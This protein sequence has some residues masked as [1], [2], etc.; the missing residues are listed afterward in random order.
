MRSLWMGKEEVT[1]DLKDRLLVT[2]GVKKTNCK[3]A[4][5]A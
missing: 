2:K 3:D 5:K 4:I 1:V